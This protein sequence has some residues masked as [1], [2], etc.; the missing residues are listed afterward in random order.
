MV[1][2][3]FHKFLFITHSSLII[4]HQSDDLHPVVEVVVSGTV[5]VVVS[6]IVVVVSAVV[7]TSAGVKVSSVV[8]SVIMLAV[9]VIVVVV[10]I[11]L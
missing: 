8:T 3:E 4:V 9:V 1:F 11:L 10:D 7:D 2:I 6:G 5:E